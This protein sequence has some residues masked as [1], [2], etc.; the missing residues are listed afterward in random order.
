LS[1]RHYN[2]ERDFDGGEV[3][4]H[5]KRAVGWREATGLSSQSTFKETQHKEILQ[6]N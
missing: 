1:E 4:I 5:S 2:N 3:K 6:I